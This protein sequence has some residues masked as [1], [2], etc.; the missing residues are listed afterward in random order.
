MNVPL[1]VAGELIGSLNVAAE[2]ADIYGKEHLLVIREVADSMA[3]ALRQAKLH[4]TVQRQTE[5]L[6]QRVRERTVELE[7]ANRE[8]E[9][10]AYTVS[11]DL[12]APLRAIDGFSMA[13]LEDAGDRLEDEG[14]QHIA[15]VRSGVQR[16]AMMIDALL[17]MSRTTRGELVRTEVDLSTA[18]TAVIEDLCQEAPDRAVEVSIEPL[19]MSHADA[20]LV[21]TLLANLLGNAWK[22]TADAE[23]ARITFGRLRESGPNGSSTVFFVRDNGVGF[24]M[25]YADKL[26]VPFQRLHS[27]NDIVG[28]GVG[29]ASAERIVRRHGGR[30]WADAEMDRGATFFFTLAP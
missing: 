21:H 20:R 1:R 11:H 2:T 23:P 3:V 8:L 26:F 12:R 9:S 30:L 14:R 28:S 10:F 15:R 17:E 5:V 24:D 4:E 25:T 27:R 6:E 19:L 18:A 16:M 7:A 13:L 29:L 22:F